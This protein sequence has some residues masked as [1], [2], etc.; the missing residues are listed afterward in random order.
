MISAYPIP[1]A[2]AEAAQE[3]KRSRFIAYLGHT[4]GRD[5]AEQMIASVRAQH[6]EARHH[7]YAFVA[8]TPQDGQQYGFSDDGEP[9]GTGGRPILNVLLGSGIGEITAVVV[10]YSGGI[11]LGTG[12]LVR[13]YGGTAQLAMQQL[14]TKA[15]VATTQLSGRCDYEQFSAL[16]TLFDACEAQVEQVEYGADVCFT[17][18]L[19]EQQ[20]DK[21]LQLA[22]DRFR[23]QQLLRKIE[24][25]QQPTGA[26]G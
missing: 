24:D 5:A 23:G 2:P 19:P 18:A 15:F 11:K 6:P 1:A 22:Q 9:A 25:E 3:I 8:G 12:G 4:P 7:C 21:L 20:S 13:A 26:K 16:S 10:R 17:L 14:N